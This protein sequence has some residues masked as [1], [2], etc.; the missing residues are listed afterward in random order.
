MPTRSQLLFTLLFVCTYLSLAEAPEPGK[1][2]RP[3]R[4]GAALPLSGDFATYGGVIRDGMRLAKNDLAAEGISIELSFEDAPTPGSSAVTALRKLIERDH[5]QGIAGNFFNPNMTVM[6]P[7]IKQHGIPAFHT[8]IVDDTIV[9]LSPHIFGTN[10]S[11][12]SEAEVLSDYLV[13]A[14]AVKKVAILF[15]GTQW[16]EAYDRQIDKHLAAMGGQVVSSQLV[17]LD[18]RDLRTELTKIRSS[19]ADAVIL[20]L[21]GP[22][23]GVAL[24][25]TRAVGIELPVVATY[26]TQDA[27]VL[28][29][30][31]RSGGPVTFFVPEPERD[32]EQRKKFKSA[33]RQMFNY[34]AP[35]L[36]ANAYDATLLLGRAL[37]ACN[38]DSA[39]ANSKLAERKE[40]DGA[41]GGYT[42]NGGFAEKKFVEKL[43][44][45]GA[46]FVRGGS[47]SE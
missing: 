10:G 9:T 13:N 36:S 29:T 16:G 6:A 17:P 19:G 44:W 7:L 28:E 38:G 32:S 47:G 42:L 37:A 12:D 23:L 31:G 21:F 26:E 22:Q 40:V 2:S 4:V 20:A 41:S 18:Q 24:A 30:A 43:L 1:Q 25:Q 3:I 14:L 46:I 45:R 5:I 27:S 11:V 35:I 34:S 15:A 8:A 33:F 39:C